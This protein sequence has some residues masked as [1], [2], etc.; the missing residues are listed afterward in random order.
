MNG[1][2]TSAPVFVCA[3]CLKERGEKPNPADTHGVC[4]RHMRESFSK[5]GFSEASIEGLLS[6]LH[7]NAQPQPAHS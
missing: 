4:E 2:V 3:W 6:K 7:K 5:A 1:Q